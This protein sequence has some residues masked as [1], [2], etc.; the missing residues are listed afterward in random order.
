MMVAAAAEEVA[1]V[2]VVVVVVGGVGVARRG[3]GRVR[4][5]DAERRR[6]CRCCIFFR[7]LFLPG[8]SRLILFYLSPLS[9]MQTDFGRVEII[10]FLMS[11]E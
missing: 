4:S 1:L 2:V 5:D 10:I 8:C 7:T 11:R 6:R 9:S 3:R